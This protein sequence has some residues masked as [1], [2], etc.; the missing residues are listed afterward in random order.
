MIKGRG[1]AALDR[2]DPIHEGLMSENSESRWHCQ[3]KTKAGRLT[4]ANDSAVV[5]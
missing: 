2:K 1:Q 3:F 5:T 4:D